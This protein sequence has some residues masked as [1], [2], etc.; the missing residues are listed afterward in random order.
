MFDEDSL[1]KKVIDTLKE[2]GFLTNPYV[3]PNGYEKNILKKI[4][5]TKRLEQLKT[6][7]EVIMENFL[8][9]K[10]FSIN[11]KD[12]EPDKIDLSLIEIKNYKQPESKIFLWWNLVW[13]SLPYTRPIGRQ[14]RFLLWD[15]HHDAPF[16]LIG[17]QSPPLRSHVRDK[18]LG[19][20]NT[21]DHY[22]INQSMYGQ[23]IG[24]LPP[25]N[26]LL[27]GKMIAMSLTSNEI[28]EV[29]AKKYDNKITL[30]NKKIL[31]PR[32]LFITTTSAYGKSSVYERLK[33]YEEKVSKF[34]GYTSGYGTFHIPQSLYEELLMYLEIKGV[35]T[36]RGYGTGPSRKLDL[37]KK[38]FRSLSIPNFI[39]HN[40]NRGYYIFFN[41]HNI[42]DIIHYNKKPVWYD[43]PFKKLEE[44]WLKRWC[45]PRSER[46]DNWKHY[47]SAI[48]FNKIKNELNNL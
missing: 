29:Y 44:F 34:I 33:Y 24:A 41:V 45:V 7:K 15:N 48:F 17:L 21:K 40:V 3:K 10:E 42:M 31:P 16:G 22:W 36:K 27:G 23:R 46:L 19:L 14:M 32:L 37:I 30:L 12:I 11:G 8:K 9:I 39:F 35:D 38:A 18:Y 43:R 13:W 20:S 1:R 5:R 26:E 6:H 25:Y 2:Q 28:R 47:N 4:H